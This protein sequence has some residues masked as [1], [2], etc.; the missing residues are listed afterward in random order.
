MNNVDFYR[1]AAAVITTPRPGWK[2]CPSG[3]C[4]VNGNA[5]DKDGNIINT[6]PPQSSATLAPQSSATL[7]PKSLRVPT[8]P[9]TMAPTMSPTY[10]PT[11][12]PT[13]SPTYAPTMAPTMSPT[14][15]P[16]MGPTMSPTYAP[17]MGPTMSPTYA[18]TMGPMATMSPTYAPTMGP[19]A[20]MGPTSAPTI[21]PKIVNDIL[22]LNSLT[23]VRRPIRQRQQLRVKENY[24]AADSNYLGISFI[25]VVVVAI[26]CYLIYRNRTSQPN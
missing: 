2:P 9:P 21:A 13:M 10:A 1:E 11:M 25:I 20:T 6:V 3:R 5:L 14:Y 19:M 8:Y 16:T 24:Q 18:P 22:N 15:A 7:A 26:I 23:R 17:T 12:A 4:D